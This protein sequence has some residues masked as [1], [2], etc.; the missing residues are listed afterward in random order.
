MITDNPINVLQIDR[1]KKR[2][3]NVVGGTTDARNVGISTNIKRAKGYGLSLNLGDTN[4]YT[5]SRSYDK[6]QQGERD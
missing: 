3:E 4:S 1:Q 2:T 6:Q 5:C